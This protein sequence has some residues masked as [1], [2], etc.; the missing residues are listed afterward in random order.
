MGIYPRGKTWWIS[1]FVGGRQRFESS[2]SSKKR[3]APLRVLKPKDVAELRKERARTNA[4]FKA[5]ATNYGVSVF[6]AHR[7]CGKRVESAP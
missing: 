3:D 4:P 5:L 7:L 6:T 2:R 1:Y